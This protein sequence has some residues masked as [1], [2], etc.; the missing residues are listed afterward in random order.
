MHYIDPLHK[1][2]PNLSND[3]VY[4]LSLVFMFQD[5][6]F[7]VMSVRLRMYQV[8]LFKFGRHLCKG[9]I[10]QCISLLHST[11]EGREFTKFNV[12]MTT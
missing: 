3:T 1:W 11:K 8:L 7:F 9:S 4:I 10:F 5:K 2:R 6:G 12:L